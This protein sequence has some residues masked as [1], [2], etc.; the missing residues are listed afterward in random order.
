ME[1]TD[2]VI[3][4]LEQVIAMTKA[5]R[6]NMEATDL[7][8]NPEEME[9]ESEHGEVPQKDDAVKWVKGRRKQQRDWHLA[10]GRC[11]EPK[12]LT[13]GDCGS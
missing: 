5:N 12:E 10:A 3:A 11:G 8:A 9:S 2:R 6:E 7:K 13:L 1:K 4:V